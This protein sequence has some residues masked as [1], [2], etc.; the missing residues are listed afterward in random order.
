MGGHFLVSMALAGFWR[1][2]TDGSFPTMTILCGAIMI[3]QGTTL[4]LLADIPLS[5]F[6]ATRGDK[7][8]DTS[9][10]LQDGV[11][12]L[13]RHPNY[14]GN[15][16]AITGIALQTGIWWFGLVWFGIQTFWCYT[17]S[18]PA[19]EQYLAEKYGKHWDEYCKKV[20]SPLFILF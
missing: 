18:M 20:P 19:H 14:L 17:Q 16:I 11:W 7:K 15:T 10:I 13:C 8:Y 9:P 1:A 2:Q 3:L 4:E 6:K 12:A 5:N